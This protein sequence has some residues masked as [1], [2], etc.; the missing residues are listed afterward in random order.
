VLTLRINVYDVKACLLF[1]S[2]GCGCDL[3]Q[4]TAL[5]PVLWKATFPKV[6]ELEAETAIRPEA[7]GMI[8]GECS[9]LDHPADGDTESETAHP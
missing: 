9:R 4:A 2:Q 3:S 6:T 5:R 8:P 1:L 7:K